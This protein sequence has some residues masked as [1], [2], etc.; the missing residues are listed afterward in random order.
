MTAQ[1][2]MVIEG[3]KYFSNKDFSPDTHQIY[4]EALKGVEFY[5][6]ILN[7]NPNNYKK[8]KTLI[9]SDTECRQVEKI[10]FNLYK[11][12]YD[13]I[14]ETGAEKIKAF[15]LLYRLLNDAANKAT[16]TKSM[17]IV[18][19]YNLISGEIDT[20]KIKKHLRAGDIGFKTDIKNLHEHVKIALDMLKRG[21]TEIAIGM[22]G[23]D[24][25][26]YIVNTSSLLSFV[27][28]LHGNEKVSE[29]YNRIN[30]IHKKYFIIQE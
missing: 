26:F 28:K 14:A 21:K 13:D 18:K 22:K 16:I 5:I 11:K 6:K 9:D 7:R 3:M 27:Y 17:Q 10:A 24:I 19:K 25:N 20:E 30:N 4:L 15:E 2:S 23:R 29:Y 12:M 1:S 8:L